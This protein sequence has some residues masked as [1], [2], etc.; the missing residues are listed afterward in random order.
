VTVLDTAGRGVGHLSTQAFFRDFAPPRSETEP[1]RGLTDR[2]DDETRA[3]LERLR[4]G[5]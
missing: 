5:E 1:P 3:R 4:R 2:L